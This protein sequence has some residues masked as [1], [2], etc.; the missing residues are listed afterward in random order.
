MASD[1]ILGTAG[2]I[3]HGK[4]ALVQALTGVDTDRLPEE[5]RRGITIELG[6]ARLDLGEVHLGIVDVPGHERFVRN[7]LAGATGIE[8]ALLVVAADDSVMPQT[9][10]H[11]EILRLLDLHDGVIALTKCDLADPDWL[12]LV[13]AEVR[14]LV[15]GTF[16]EDAPLVRTSAATG[17][18]IDALRETLKQAA[19]RAIPRFTRA[20]GLPM[21]RT[22]ESRHAERDPTPFRMAIDRVFT[23]AGHGT[24]VTGSVIS[25]SASVGD[26]LSVEPGGIAVRVRGVQSHDEPV[27]SVHRGQRA[28]INLAG[29]HHSDVLRGQELATPNYLRPSRLLTVRLTLLRTAP[30]PLKNR[31]RVRLHLGA[32]DVLATVVL[33]SAEHPGDSEATAVPDIA[34]RSLL[35]GGTALAQLH[36][37]DEV[38]ATWHQPFVIRWPSPVETIGGGTVLQPNAA[39][40]RP[41]DKMAIDRVWQLASDH[42][43]I[44]LGAAHFFAGWDELGQLDLMRTANLRFSEEVTASLIE[45]GVLIEFT[46]SRGSTRSVHADVLGAFEKRLAAVLSTMHRDEPLRRA[47]DPGHVARRAATTDT[48]Q[49]IWPTILEHLTKTGE[50][51]VR[52]A[53][54]RLALAGAGPQLS[55]GER[56]LLARMVA[57]IR[58][59]GLKPPS[60][61]ELAASAAKHKAATPDLLA[62]AA[63]DGLLTRI[64]RKLFLHAETLG[65]VQQQLREGLADGQGKTLSEIREL[66]GTTRKFAV[67][68]CEHLDAVGF[69]KRHGDQRF[70]AE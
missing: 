30:R 58:A 42:D 64:S 4:T 16:L 70:L 29:I 23:I 2:H 63:A 60:V 12:E 35:P 59:A 51:I 61:D 7:M 55:R 39:R 56:E 25:G 17:D 44:R 26:E 57:Q 15:A 62:L 32:A 14:E 69:T 5:K 28:A 34:Q 9:R 65:D 10:E 52:Q 6:F 46:D 37:A 33:L 1:L 43:E 45:N 36:L 67:P 41:R 54:G 3:D 13:E 31:S 11:L 48:V 66:L 38:V 27:E 19:G 40:I 49:R 8:L 18:G 21:G 50:T 24:V 22:G 53:D 68:I 20:G 47:F